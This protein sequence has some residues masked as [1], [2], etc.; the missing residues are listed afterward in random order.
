MPRVRSSRSRA[1][2]MARDM[3][4]MN[5]DVVAPPDTW[6]I[7]FADLLTLLLSFFIMRL[8]MTTNPHQTLSELFDNKQKKEITRQEIIEERTNALRNEVVAAISGSPENALAISDNLEIGSTE[9]GTI[10][11][12]KGGSFLPGSDVLSKET[13]GLVALVALLLKEKPI[14]ITIAG[15][16]DS[17]PISNALFPSNWELSGARAI[18]VAQLLMK[19]GIPGERLSAV[20]YAETKPRADNESPEGKEKNRRVEILLRYRDLIKQKDLTN[21]TLSDTPSFWV[22]PTPSSA[23][24]ASPTSAALSLSSEN[25]ATSSAVTPID[26]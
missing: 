3:R 17:V 9:A 15:H 11:A 13:E 8:A 4:G 21:Q 22:D 12:L 18:A 26:R 6:S 19:Q 20:G 25:G 10:L 14:E 24:P 16:T 2:G 23:S 5:R 1:R 7:S